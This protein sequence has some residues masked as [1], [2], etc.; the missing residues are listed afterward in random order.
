[1]A[2]FDKNRKRLATNDKD[3]NIDMTNPSNNAGEPDKKAKHYLDMVTKENMLLLKNVTVTEKPRLY[4][5][6]QKNEFATTI[7]FKKN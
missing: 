5:Q 7:R 3:N 1:M 6:N 4:Y 2:T